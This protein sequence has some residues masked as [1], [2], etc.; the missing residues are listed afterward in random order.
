MS[1]KVFLDSNQFKLEF[2][3]VYQ[4]STQVHQSPHKST[5]VYSAP[6]QNPPK[7]TPIPPSSSKSIQVYLEST[8]IRPKSNKIFLESS[9]IKLCPPEI[10]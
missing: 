3:D 2:T 10:T 1:T 6:T 8:Q 5:K 9:Q 7:F 4:E